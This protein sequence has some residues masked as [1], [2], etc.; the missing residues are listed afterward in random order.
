MCDKKYI[1]H[2]TMLLSH[3]ETNRLCE[4]FSERLEQIQRTFDTN[5]S[6]DDL[7]EHR[8]FLVEHAQPGRCIGMHA[9]VRNAF[10]SLL[11]FDCFVFD[12]D[13]CLDLFTAA[14]REMIGGA[15]SFRLVSLEGNGHGCEKM[16]Y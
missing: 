8:S 5:P 3:I 12:N 6:Q 16:C 7:P 11:D 1:K 2:F 9:N 4:T 15:Q 14:E 10:M 13:R